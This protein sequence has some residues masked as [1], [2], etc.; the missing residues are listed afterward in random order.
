MKWLIGLIIIVVVG[1][2][3][4]IFL[5]QQISGTPAP[6]SL[7]ITNG[8]LSSC[9]NAPNCVSSYPNDGYAKNSPIRYVGTQAEA[10]AKLVQLLEALP[11]TKIVSAE[12]N[13]LHAVQTSSFWGFP[14]DIEFYLDDKENIIHFRSASRLGRGDMNINQKRMEAII[15]AFNQ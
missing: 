12:S 14:D 1:S 7:G 10:K 2:I 3:I 5:R 6:T 11:N 8:R 4:W 13:Y 15:S 9:P